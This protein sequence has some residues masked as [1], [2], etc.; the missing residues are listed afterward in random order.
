MLAECSV[1][2]GDPVIDH[3]R[4]GVDLL[5]PSNDRT[6]IIDRVLDVRDFRQ[7]EIVVRDG[8][9]G[10]F[11]NGL[12]IPDL[13]GDDVDLSVFRF[14]ALNALH[15]LKPERIGPTV[16]HLG[17]IGLQDVTVSLRVGLV[18]LRRIALRVALQIGTFVFR[19]LVHRR[20]RRE[21]EG[22]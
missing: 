8:L 9:P 11:Q 19:R 18:G 6:P 14:P 21:Q 13:L 7:F 16:V 20:D 17:R 5:Q 10:G 12:I 22:V 3:D 1:F 15:F 2:G 4:P